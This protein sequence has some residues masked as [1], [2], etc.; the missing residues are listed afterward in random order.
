MSMPGTE[1]FYIGL[2]HPVSTAPPLLALLGIGVLLGQA[3]LQQ[4][5]TSLKAFALAAALGLLLGVFGVSHP[6]Q[7]PLLLLIAVTA[8]SLAA[9]APPRLEI[10]RILLAGLGGL[11]IG[12][13]SAP[14]PGPLRATL[15][16]VAGSYVGAN[17]L[18]LYA[19]GGVIW[20]REHLKQPWVHI[21]LRVVS[22]WIAAISCLMVALS[23]RGT[24][25]TGL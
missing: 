9:I 23:A 5:I 8:S 3:G 6:V 2:L 20:I 22:A 18:L 15:V 1:G 14:D 4:A 21:G 24:F 13:V 12:I 17:A 7:E 25:G 16:T 10:P 11:L 19:S